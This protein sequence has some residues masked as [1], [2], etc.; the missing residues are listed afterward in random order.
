MGAG[1][2]L[3]HNESGST[4]RPNTPPFQVDW[5]DIDQLA[6]APNS[7]LAHLRSGIEFACTSLADEAP[8]AL[9]RTAQRNEIEVEQT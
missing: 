2:L 5:A 9:A 3:L 4:A 8:P 7:F 1:G 6:P